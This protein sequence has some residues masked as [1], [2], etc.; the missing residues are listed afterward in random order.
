MS[1]GHKSES[2]AL[3][4]Y[5]RDIKRKVP[6]GWLFIFLVCEFFPPSQDH[7]YEIWKGHWVPVNVCS[8]CRSLSMD[9]CQDSRLGYIILN[10]AFKW[11]DDPH[12]FSTGCLV[13]APCG[14]TENGDTQMNPDDLLLLTGGTQLQHTE[15]LAAARPW[16]HS[17]RTTQHRRRLV[18]AWF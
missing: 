4:I 6:E 14:P 10:S 15:K 3:E 16:H 7:R 1:L 11:I 18:T 5:S 8:D 9:S 2:N 13:A 12:Y 17:R